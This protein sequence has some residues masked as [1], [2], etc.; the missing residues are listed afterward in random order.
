MKL[1]YI[2]AIVFFVIGASELKACEYVET[3][4]DMSV[5]Y[6]IMGVK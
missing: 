5:A 6:G 1:T 4:T 2:I 3:N